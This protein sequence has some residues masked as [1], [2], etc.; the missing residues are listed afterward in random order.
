MPR[1]S[2]H[3]FRRD[4]R[5]TDNT[6]LHAAAASS[7]Q[8]VPVY[9]LSDWRRHHSWT[10]PARQ[11]FLCGSLASLDK[12]LGCLLTMRGVD[13]G[14]AVAELERARGT[15]VPETAEQR[16]WIDFYA[17]SLSHTK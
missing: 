14:S 10:G 16:G 1:I 8:V 4:L 9:I 12:N 13:S 11:S 6:A 17:A 2:L 5:L 3:W 15:P 7:D